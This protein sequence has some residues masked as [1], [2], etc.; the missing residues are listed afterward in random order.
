MNEKFQEEMGQS[1]KEYEETK[2]QIEEDCDTEV[3][4]IKAKYEKKLKEQ[5]ELN[6]KAT[7]EA[8]NIRKKVKPNSERK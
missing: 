8:T 4:D 3:I 7:S 2:R 1:T 5:I 6:E